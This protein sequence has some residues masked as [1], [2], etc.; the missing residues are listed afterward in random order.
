MASVQTTSNGSP[1]ISSLGQASPPVAMSSGPIHQ[2]LLVKPGCSSLGCGPASPLGN[3]VTPSSL[4]CVLQKGTSLPRNSLFANA[5]LSP[6]TQPVIL[7]PATTRQ[8]VH[9][10][11]SSMNVV[12]HRAPPAIQPKHCLN[13]QTKALQRSPKPSLRPNSPALHNMEAATQQQTAV[14]NPNFP[15]DAP[16]RNVVLPPWASSPMTGQTQSAQPRLDNPTLVHVPTQASTLSVPQ[17]VVPAKRRFILP[18]HLAS[19]VSRLQPLP[20]A[21]AR[22]GFTG[23]SSVALG[24][25]RQPAATHIVGH[26]GPSGQLNAKKPS[27]PQILTGQSTA[28]HRTNFGQVSAAPGRQPVVGGGRAGVLTGP[29]QLASSTLLRV[30]THPDADFPQSRSSDQCVRSV[31]QPMLLPNRITVPGDTGPTEQPVTLQQL[32]AVPSSSCGVQPRASRNAELTP[33]LG[34]LQTRTPPPCCPH[35]PAQLQGSWHHPPPLSVTPPHTGN[36]LAEN[37]GQCISQLDGRSTLNCDQLLLFQQVSAFRWSEMYQYSR[38]M[39]HGGSIKEW[40]QNG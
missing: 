11:P 20:A 25:P 12:V 8:V 17:P 30:P 33:G 28:W 2:Q 10:P 37:T 22:A 40:Q 35:A 21:C 34:L 15:V 26:Q 7:K 38:L 16:V 9:P 4:V 32:S 31:V 29:S 39:E 14:L 18:G 19:V 24:L 27:P 13:I 3:Q 23:Q 5:S 36:T 1:G 6:P